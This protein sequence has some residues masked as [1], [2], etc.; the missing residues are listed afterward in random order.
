VLGDS[1]L[2][3][4][5]SAGLPSAASIANTPGG[6]DTRSLPP[7]LPGCRSRPGWR[8]ACWTKKPWPASSPCCQLALLLQLREVRPAVPLGA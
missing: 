6:L 5:P 4:L 1:L 8:R 7:P 2:V 3:L